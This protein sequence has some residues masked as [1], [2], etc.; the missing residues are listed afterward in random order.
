[1][2]H[3]LLLIV[4]LLAGCAGAPRPAAP[5]AEAPPSVLERL[6]G[7][8]TGVLEY[9]DYGNGRRVQLQTEMEATLADGGSTLRLALKFRE[10]NG[11]IVEGSDTHAIDVAA[12]R[13]VIDGDTFA[14]STLRGFGEGEGGA[15]VLDGRGRE[16]DAPVPA[17]QTL[18]LSGDS[19]RITRETRDPLQFR[20]EYRFVRRR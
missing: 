9:A 10:P 1:M 20:N 15:L 13:Y 14:I 17:R 4:P 19:L 12:G 7:A 3:A 11:R 5:S 16:N 6:A 18:V 2:R 8:W